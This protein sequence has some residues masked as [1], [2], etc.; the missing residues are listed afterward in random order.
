MYAIKWSISV[1]RGPDLTIVS[2]KH[3]KK[4]SV[5]YNEHFYFIL[6]S[7]KQ[8][9]LVYKYLLIANDWLMSSS[10]LMIYFKPMAHSQHKVIVWDV[11]S[12]TGAW[13]AVSTL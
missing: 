7:W 5:L 10:Y 1:K 4:T 3:S 12:I 2:I 11:S 13:N 6:Y 9:E 8:I